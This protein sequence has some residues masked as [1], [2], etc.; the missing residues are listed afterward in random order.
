MMQYTLTIH[1]LNKDPEYYF[2]VEAFDSG[3]DYYRERTEQTMGRGAEIELMKDGEML[4]R[5][6]LMKVR[7]SMFLIVLYQAN[8]SSDILSVLY[9]GKEN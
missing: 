4:E 1:S 6:M 8:I 3:T 2:K 5:K 7:M 9:C